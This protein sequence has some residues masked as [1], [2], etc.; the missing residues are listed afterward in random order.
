MHFASPKHERTYR[1]VIKG[2]RYPPRTL[3]ALFLLTADRRLWRHWRLAVAGQGIDWTTDVSHPDYGWDVD[4]LEKA[5]ISL[6]RYER[7]QIG[8]ATQAV[9][10]YDLADCGAYPT[11]LILLVLSALLLARDERRPKFRNRKG[12]RAC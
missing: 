2:H 10:L 7:P 6:V 4:Y 9:T 1:N 3:A 11:E 8:K 5:A 12:K